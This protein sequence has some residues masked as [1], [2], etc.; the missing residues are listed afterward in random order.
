V[1]IGIDSIVVADPYLVETI[2]REFDVDVV[3]SVLA[4]VDSPQKAEFFENLGAKSIVIDSNVNRHFDVLH[5]IRDSVD[6]EL[7][8]LVN[9]AAFTAV[10]SGMRILIFSHM[11]SGRNQGQMCLMIIIT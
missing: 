10:L 7:K 3:V 2:S 1:D 8:L 6:C 11:L 9:E 4:F 5:A